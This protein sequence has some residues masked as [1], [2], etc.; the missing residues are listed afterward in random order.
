MID[1][2][3]LAAMGTA[4][5]VVA[6]SPGPG[7]L[8]SATVSMMHGRRIGLTFAAGLASGLMF[9]GLLA[10]MGMGAV[11]QSSATVLFVLKLLGGGYL[12][13]LALQSG[14][15]AV[16]RT[17]RSNLNA[18]DGRWYFRGLLLNLS[19]PK[20][21]LAWMA[22]F[23]VGLTSENG[24]SQLVAGMGLCILITIL[25]ATFWAILFSV[26]GVMSAYRKTKRNVDVVVS[27]LFAVAGLGMIR[28]AFSR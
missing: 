25:N 23:S 11:L 14:R 15:S 21:I 28:S 26:E 17:A 10:A 2:T 16:N 12:L 19:N 24:L 6:A 4:F 20:A 22:A 7:N 5:F 18:T 13:W 1:F 8:A 9:W 27:G 3:T